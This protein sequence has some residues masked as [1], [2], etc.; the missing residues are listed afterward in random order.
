MLDPATGVCRIASAGHPAPLLVSDGT[1]VGAPVVPRPLLGLGSGTATS[2]EITLAP[3]STL[4]VY[5]DGLVEK[6]GTDLQEQVARLR[7]LAG[8]THPGSSLDG[9]ID[10]LLG[11]H[12]D[13]P[14]DDTTLLAVRLTR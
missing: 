1:A 11:L 7:D 6:R 4:L 8:S 5:T 2:A 3:G 14:T 9:W 12:P 13:V 10:G